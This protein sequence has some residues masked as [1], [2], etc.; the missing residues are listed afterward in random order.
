MKIRQTEY[1]KKI[2]IIPIGS[3]WRQRMRY[4]SITKINKVD[5]AWWDIQYKNWILS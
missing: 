1:T 5:W 2:I 3:V 4:S